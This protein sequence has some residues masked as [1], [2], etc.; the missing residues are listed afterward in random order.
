MYKEPKQCWR[1]RGYDSTTEIFDQSVP[2]GQMTESSMKE[3]L[4]ALAG[5]HLSPREV[6]G[7]YAKRGTSISNEFVAI[8]RVNQPEEERTIYICGHN[9]HYVATIATCG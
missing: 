2:I 7:A 8:H 5:R 6:I 1:I 9:P 4:R 3:L